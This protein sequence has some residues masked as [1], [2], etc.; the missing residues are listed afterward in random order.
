LRN[1][2]IKDEEAEEADVNDSRA[3]GRPNNY[4]LIILDSYYS[5]ILCSY[6]N[7]P[8]HFFA[9]VV[10]NFC[11]FEYGVTQLLIIKLLKWFYVTS[12]TSLIA[13]KI[14]YNYQ[15]S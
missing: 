7:F 11:C 14:K 6:R 8:L 13:L 3:A 9:L 5:V 2:I 4:S 10:T 1:A 12:N 15:E